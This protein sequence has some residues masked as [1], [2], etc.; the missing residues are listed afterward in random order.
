MV[1]SATRIVGSDPVR[2]V[3]LGVGMTGVVAAGAGHAGCVR[4][5]RVSS[6][7]FCWPTVTVRNNDCASSN[8]IAL[9]TRELRIAAA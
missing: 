1:V 7:D 4:R 5:G 3:R 9:R 2:T 8:V 6:P